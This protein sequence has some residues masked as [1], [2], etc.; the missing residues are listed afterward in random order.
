MTLESSDRNA[1]VDEV[2]LLRQLVEIESPSLDT[3]ASDEIAQL[4]EAEF[5]R[6]DAAVTHTRTEAGTSLT[7][8]VGGAGEDAGRAPLLLVGHTD[9]VWPVGTLAGDVPWSHDGDRIAGPGAFD[10]KSGI[11][12]MHAALARL[13]G[14]A[15]RRA[16][17]VL[18]CDEEIGSPTTQGL[19]RAAAADVAGVLG[20][21][22]P[23]P[24]GALKVGRWGSTRLRLGITGKASHAALDPEHGISAI[25]ELVDQLMRVREITNDPTLVSPVL[26]NVGTVAGG[27]RTNVVPD[28]ASAEIGLRF[29]NPESE[30]SVLDRLASLA[31]CRAGAQ[32]TVETLSSRPAW[33][34]SERDTALLAEVTSA[35]HRIGQTVSGRPAHGAGDTNLLGSLG[36]PTLDG[37]GP[38]GGGAHAVTEHIFVSSL[39]ERIDLLTEALRQP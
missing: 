36:I 29:V 2:A 31:P 24:D 20:F 25:D 19:L 16:R 23:H 33:Q 13:A 37:L 32:L 5:S 9:T 22:S 34:A 3:Q 7:I 15:H 18:T 21:E 27:G 28:H 30:H 26:C 10:M 4:I 38:R 6:L 14:H 35:A 11:V 8:D 39:M 12:I 17:I 1:G